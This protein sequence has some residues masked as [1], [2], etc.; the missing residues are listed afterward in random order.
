MA[1]TINEPQ[2]LF[3]CGSPRQARDLHRVANELGDCRVWFTPYYGGTLVTALRELGL[4]ERTV[5]GKRLG[6]ECLRYLRNQHLPIDLDGRRGRYDL[7]VTCS[8][9]ALPPNARG[10][11]LVVVATNSHDRAV[12]AERLF[13]RIAQRVSCWLALDPG[14]D[15]RDFSRELG[16][17]RRLVVGPAAAGQG[18]AAERVARVCRELLELGQPWGL[19]TRPLSAA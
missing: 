15:E 19:D 13:W 14:D 18:S 12:A 16:V 10:H 8:D 5:A 7:V 3:I 11:R 1:F 2:V 17:P 9:L 6:E 4:L